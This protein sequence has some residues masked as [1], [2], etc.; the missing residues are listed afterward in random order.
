MSNRQHACLDILG[1]EPTSCP[2]KRRRDIGL[3][4]I[5]VL[6]T[7]SRVQANNTY[8]LRTRSDGRVGTERDLT[9][10]AETEDHKHKSAQELG[11]R[12]ADD[13]PVDSSQ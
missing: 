1:G 6:G 10:V 4:G 8:A 2:T 3:I 5:K 9:V 12:F 7:E 11:G 13:L